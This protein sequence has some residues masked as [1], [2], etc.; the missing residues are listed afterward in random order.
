MRLESGGFPPPAPA[1]IMD[2]PIDRRRCTADPRC[3]AV[4]AGGGTRLRLLGLGLLDG[5]PTTPKP[6]VSEADI[7][8]TRRAPGRARPARGIVDRFCG[9]GWGSGFSGMRG[10]RPGSSGQNR[11]ENACRFCVLRLDRSSSP[12]VTGKCANRRLWPI[13]PSHPIPIAAGAPSLEASVPPMDRY[14]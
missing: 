8:R 14:R 2:R 5:R 12:Q 13:G 1:A 3:G 9:C 4:I 11:P 6:A 10:N 7:A